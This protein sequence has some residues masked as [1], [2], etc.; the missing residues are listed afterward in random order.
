MMEMKVKAEAMIA[1]KKQKNAAAPISN[2]RKRDESDSDPDY[3]I[4]SPDQ[5][6]VR[7]PPPS[8]A[9]S[10]AGPLR[11]IPCDKC[12]AYQLECRAG[13]KDSCTRCHNHKCACKTNGVPTLMEPELKKAKLAMK[14]PRKTKT[15]AAPKTA[16]T[17]APKKPRTPAPKK[18]TSAPAKTK[19]PA[20]VKKKTAPKSKEF[21]DSED[22]GESEAP[23]KPKSTRT[24]TA[25]KGKTSGVDSGDQL[26]PAKEIFVKRRRV[27]TVT[28]PAPR[29][30][31]LE[32]GK[33]KGFI[34]FSVRLNS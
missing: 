29:F 22:E 14:T 15:P 1:L 23:V 3:E 8:N 21:V 32:K 34:Y 28:Q 25:P 2:K 33:S 27:D 31:T 20:P 16:K 7:K 18:T 11:R 30:S 26:E 4:S 24:K 19:T 10:S 17:P 5:S 13:P 6:P 12:A 9:Q